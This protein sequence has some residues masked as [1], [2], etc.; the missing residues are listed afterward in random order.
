MQT[1]TFL[2]CR[3][4]SLP[5]PDTE[6]SRNVVAANGI[7]VERHSETFTTSVRVSSNDLDLEYHDEFCVL[8]CGRIPRSLHR[9]MLSFFIDAHEAHEGEAALVLLYHPKRRLF[10]WHCPEQVVDRYETR[11]GRWFAGDTI[12]YSNPLTLPEGYVHFGDAHLHVGAAVPSQIDLR[13][14]GDG[15]HIIVGNIASRKPT[16]HVDF[17]MDRHRFPIAPEAIFDDPHCEPFNGT[18]RSWL[19]QIYVCSHDYVPQK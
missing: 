2:S 6:S 4:D 3:F 13:D 14:D 8:K 18:P 11:D 16:Y 5:E 7:F 15:L 1:P 17:V 10:R 12:A 19:R 9:A